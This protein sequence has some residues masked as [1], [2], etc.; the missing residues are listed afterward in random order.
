MDDIFPKVALQRDWARVSDTWVTDG[1]GKIKYYRN[2][3]LLRPSQNAKL[4]LAAS[5]E[6]RLAMW[7]PERW[8]AW[9]AS[10]EP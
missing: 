10:R 3:D 7:F 1:K 6:R 2:I 9:L 5:M 8:T 4:A